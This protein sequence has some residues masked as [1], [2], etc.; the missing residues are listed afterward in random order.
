MQPIIFNEGFN[1][2]YGDIIK[3]EGTDTEHNLGKTTLVHLIDFLLL[4]NLTKKHPFS[5]YKN[6]F[7]GWTFYIELKLD[8]NRYL[9]IKRSVDVP[10]LVSFKEHELPNQD[11]S[12]SDSWDQKD[13]R[14]NSKKSIDAVTALDK[15]LNFNVL[16]NYSYRHFL[17]YLLRTQ[18]DYEDIF[19]M[20]QFEGLDIDWKPQLFSILGYS[21]EFVIQKYR[22]QYEIGTYNKLLKTIIGNKKSKT[23]DSYNLKAAITEIENE[24]AQIIDQ[25]SKFDF[26]LR[27]K[28]LNK[29]LV[30]EIETKI[31]KLNSERYRLDNEINRLKESLM[32]SVA[33]DLNE[34]KEVF[35][36]TNI[37][38]PDA[39]KKNYEELLDFNNALSKERAKYLKEDLKSNTET[40]K[41]ISTELMKFNAEKEQ[42]LSFLRD[43][44][45]F[46][47]YKSL[48][49]KVTELDEQITNYK[50]KLDSLGT[51]ENY[52]KKIDELKTESKAV[53]IKVKEVIDNGSATFEAINN[54]FKEFFKKIMGHTALIVVKPNKEGNPDIEPITLD[55]IEADQLTGQSDGYT[56]TKIQ[57]AG[58]ILAIL[59]TYS[60]E[61]FFK[62]A[63]HDGLIESWSDKLKIKFF[64]EIREICNTYGVQYTISVI[65]SDVPDGFVFK[66]DEIAVTLSEEKTLLGI[67]F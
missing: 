34:V 45:T 3:K 49:N 2:V 48:Q 52:E 32:S 9:T 23:N 46:S 25:I 18:Y 55:D 42:I 43:T 38:F 11:F 40:L 5:K 64:D 19:K 66:K 44:D 57:C 20:R 58:F 1:V 33:F 39:L 61:R 65:K 26:Y 62:F 7:T 29:E 56:A 60:K 27:E 15:Y 54:F 63:Y 8:D 35:E 24:K 17:A 4:K 30:Y 51:A 16:Q 6:K 50:I 28:N 67:N 31:S 10:T 37:F 47:K 21:D 22:L 13:L 36:Q 59:V 12:K 41:A 14:M 53:A